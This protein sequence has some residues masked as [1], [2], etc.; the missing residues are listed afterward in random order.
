LGLQPHLAYQILFYT[1]QVFSV[2][3]SA[4]IFAVIYSVFEMAMKPMKGLLRMGKLVF[5]WVAAVSLL[6]GVVI[7][8]G[9]HVFTTGEASTIAVTTVIERVQEGVNV[10][11]LGLLLFVCISIKP[12]GL[13]F[14]SRVFGVALGLGIISMTDLVQ[15]AWFW[16]TQAHSLYSPIFLFSAI[17]YMVAFGTWGGYFLVREPERKMVLLPTTSPFFHWNRISEALGGAPGN[18]AIAFKP[19]MISPTEVKVMTAMS[20]VAKEREA[21]AAMVAAGTEAEMESIAVS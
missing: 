15:A 20:R 2:L 18:V 12:L 11:T 17:G 10:L 4:A 21:Q 16:T 1:T 19:S 7:A 3:Q 5:K 13:T 9:P 6:L 14:R 8:L